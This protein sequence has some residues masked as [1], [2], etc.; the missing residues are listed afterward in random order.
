MAGIL[1]DKISKTIDANP[2]K[3]E[4]GEKILENTKKR[5]RIEI[6]S[7]KMGTFTEEAY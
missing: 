4:G 5:R 2:G 3:T 1:F 6:T 7:K